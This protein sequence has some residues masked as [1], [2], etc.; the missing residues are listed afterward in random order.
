MFVSV[1]MVSLKKNFK[2]SVVNSKNVLS[3]NLNSFSPIQSSHYN[4]SGSTKY[5]YRY[6]EK[7]CVFKVEKT[8]SVLFH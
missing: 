6:A 4:I 5:V 8:V 2:Y 3:P 1:V 7:L